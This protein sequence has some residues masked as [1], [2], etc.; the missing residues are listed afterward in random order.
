MLDDAEAQAAAARCHVQAARLLLEEESKATALEQTAT[1]T[2]R[3]VPSSSASSSSPL[4]ASQLIPTASSTYKDTV[5]AGLHLQAATVLNV[6]Q[7]VN[8]VL[9][10]SS[11]NYVCW[12]DLMEQALQRYALI[13]HVTDDTPS[14]DP[15]WIRMDSVVLNW[16]SNSISTDRHQVVRERG[17]TTRHLCLTIENQFLDNRE[18]RTLYLD[19]AFHT[20]V[21]G[22][23]LVNEYCRKFKAMA[24]GLA[25]LG[26]PVEDRILVLNILRGLNQC[27][28]HVGSI[29][30]RYSPFPNFLKVQDDLLLEEIHMDS[31]G[32]LAA[33]TA[34]YTNVAF[35]VAKPPSRPPNG[36][37]GGTDG[38][39]TKHNNKNHNSGN[40]GGHNDKNSTGDGG[41][42]GSSGQTT[43]PTG[44]VGRTNAPWPTYDHSWQGHMTMY[45]G[46]VPV[47]QHRPHAFVGT[48]SLYASPSLLSGPQPQQQQPLYQ[49][50]APA[51][52]WNP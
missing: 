17:C 20:F 33:P 52:G 14:N 4:T 27:F 35:P 26:A 49:Q 5:V 34:L 47:G 12:R 40:G 36:G 46:P 42:G 18:Q 31:T 37:N 32:P 23:L 48:P 44:Y 3:R 7:L 11:T 16:I 6:R 9:D 19:A 45:P 29:I 8:I 28:E 39:Q 15:G 21:Q 38:N 41:C 30:R 2:R 51:P 43:A 22:D 24:D 13:K 25:D 1:V 50:A 10:S